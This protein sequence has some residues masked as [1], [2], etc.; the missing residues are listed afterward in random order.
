MGWGGAGSERGGGA[1]EAGDRGDHA[2]GSGGVGASLRRLLQ[3]RSTAT[4][5]AFGGTMLASSA[6]NNIFVTYYMWVRPCQELLFV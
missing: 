1:N 4:A 3:Q 6:L 5:V 2:G